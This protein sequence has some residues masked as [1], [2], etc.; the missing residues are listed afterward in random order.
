MCILTKIHPTIRTNNA[1]SS[2][3]KP[4]ALRSTTR[5]NTQTAL[6]SQDERTVTVIIN[7]TRTIVTRNFRYIFT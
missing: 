2:I 6:A 4:S 3:P 1:R 5:T 7:H